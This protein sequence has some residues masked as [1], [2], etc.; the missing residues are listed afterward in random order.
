MDERERL[1]P[2][3]SPAESG[4][5]RFHGAT[6]RRLTS[7]ERGRMR[8]IWNFLSMDAWVSRAQL[9]KLNIYFL[10]WLESL[11]PQYVPERI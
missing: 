3:R 1:Q 5:F 4:G 10:M 7:D 2:A 9:L 6:R 11:S 8:D